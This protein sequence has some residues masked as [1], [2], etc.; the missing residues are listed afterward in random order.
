[1][2]AR[3]SDRRKAG[4]EVKKNIYDAMF[5]FYV[6]EKL[7]DGYPD[8]P[9]GEDEK[10]CQCGC[11]QTHLESFGPRKFWT[12]RG[13][14]KISFLT[15]RCLPLVLLLSGFYLKSYAPLIQKQ[16]VPLKHC[17]G[18]QQLSIGSREYYDA[19]LSLNKL[20]SLRS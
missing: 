4:S 11:G 13:V 14:V 15:L 16:P 9:L 5:F 1:M 2:K 17:P 10:D 12:A 18:D 20:I 19:R 8:C 7:C 6:S 3:R